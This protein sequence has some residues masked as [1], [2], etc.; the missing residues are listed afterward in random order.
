MVP[1]VAATPSIPGRLHKQS[2]ALSRSTRRTST[3]LEE[4]RRRHRAAVPALAD[5]LVS[6]VIQDLIEDMKPEL[7]KYVQRESAARAYIARK[8]RRQE[9]IREWSVS[10]MEEMIDE[11]VST[12]TG[13]VLKEEQRRRSRLERDEELREKADRAD[14]DKVKAVKERQEMLDRLRLMGLGGSVAV[15]ESVGPSSPAPKS[16]YSEDRLDEFETDVALL[17]VSWGVL[18]VGSCQSL[19][20]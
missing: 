12:L 14:R 5:E 19:V 16:V 8:R 10:V 1:A 2:L 13:R 3:S 20:F 15:R 6:Q 9:D 4:Q 11:I 7:A 17:Q 18:A